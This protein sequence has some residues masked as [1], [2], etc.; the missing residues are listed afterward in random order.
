M[1]EVL[2][3]ATEQG[4]GFYVR[5]EPYYGLGKMNWPPFAPNSRA[6]AQ[7]RVTAR[8]LTF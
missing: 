8:E 2:Q 6:P 1:F 4:A 5:T 3:K 7:L